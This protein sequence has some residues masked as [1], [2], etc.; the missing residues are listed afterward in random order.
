MSERSL[1]APIVDDV[2]LKRW[3][4]QVSKRLNELAGPNVSSGWA[5]T[6]GTEDKTYDANATTVAE[7]ADVLGTLIDTLIA[8]GVLKD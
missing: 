2:Q 8:A 5:V 7:L 3:M 6:N 4:E 1:K